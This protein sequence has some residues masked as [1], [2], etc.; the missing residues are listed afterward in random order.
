[1][2]KAPKIRTIKPETVC[3]GDLIKVSLPHKD[4]VKSVVGRVARREYESGGSV[5]YTAENEV[6][7]IYHPAHKPLFKITLMHRQL[8]DNLTLEGL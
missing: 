1:M 2:R 4:T 8:A 5:S 3:I 6:L 7:F